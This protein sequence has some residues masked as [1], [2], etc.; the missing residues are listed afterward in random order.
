MLHISV[1][2]WPSGPGDLK[3]LES[4]P[5]GE[6]RPANRTLLW[7]CGA[8]WSHGLGTDPW[9]FLLAFAAILLAAARLRNHTNPKAAIIPSAAQAPMMIP[10]P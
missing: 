8:G 3:V 1:V 6:E 7:L 4:T 5:A 9:M 10:M 2:Q